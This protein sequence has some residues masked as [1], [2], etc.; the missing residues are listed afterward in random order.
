MN[1][2]LLH[3]GAHKVERTTLD[4]IATPPAT[5]TWFPIPHRSLLGQ[6]ENKLRNSGLEIVNEAHALTHDGNRYFGLLQVVSDEQSRDFAL[7]LGIRNSH[8][9]SFPA[10]L[11]VGASVF[12]CDNL[13]FSGEIR[14]DRKHTK[15]INRDLPQLVEAAVGRL[16]DQRHKQELRFLTY[17]RTELSDSEAHDLVIQAL[18]AQVLPVTKIPDVLDEWRHPRHPEFRAGKT[19]WRLFNSF[20]EIGK[21]ALERLPRRTQALHGILDSHVGLLTVDPQAGL[22]VPADAEVAT[23]QAV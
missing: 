9:Q 13:S 6:V 2:L 7:V 19:A 3:C 12:C 16:A 5:E 1:D 17:Q 15:F 10:G 21:G 23:P 4:L 18:D 8:G 22:A 20:T 11:V 14:I